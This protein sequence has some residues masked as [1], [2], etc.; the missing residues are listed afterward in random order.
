MVKEGRDCTRLSNEGPN[1]IGSQRHFLNFH[2]SNR[3]S[4]FVFA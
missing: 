1:F 2:L 4:F 3:K